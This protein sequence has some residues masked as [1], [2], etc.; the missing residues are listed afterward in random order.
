MP[1]TV[2]LAKDPWLGSS[3]TQEVNLGLLFCYI[4]SSFKLAATF[5]S[6][7]PQIRAAVRFHQMSCFAQWMEI[8]AETNS[9]PKCRYVSVDAQL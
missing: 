9:W 1:G 6:L 4:D 3:E 2:N 8:N 5:F 7:F